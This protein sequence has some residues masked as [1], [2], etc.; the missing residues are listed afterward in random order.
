MRLDRYT[1]ACRQL[2]QELIES[3][4]ESEIDQLRSDL[5]G[6]ALPDWTEYRH[7]VSGT[8]EPYVAATPSKRAKMHNPQD[9]GFLV[10]AAIQHCLEAA[11]L[12][13][14]IEKIDIY[15][16]AS[17]RGVAGRAGTAFAEL[18]D[19]AACEWPFDGASPF[20]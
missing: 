17:Y 14:Q 6:T 18:C 4:T 7:S 13:E 12:L 3:L 16:Q 15:P 1:N 19:C 9:K 8:V 20:E 11:E 5:D 10:L 2:A